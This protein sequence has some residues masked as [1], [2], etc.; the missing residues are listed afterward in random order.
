MFKHCPSCRG[1]FQNWVER[2]PDCGTALVLAEAKPPPETREELPPASE[3]VCLERGDP[4]TLHEI[5]QRF[6]AAGLSCR[7]DV[8]P[9]DGK[10]QLGQRG[11]G[12][13]TPFG[14]YV[15]ARDE[16]EAKRIRLEQ[17]RETLPEAAGH[18]LGAGAELADCP[19]CGEPL[20]E[21][22]RECA[23]CGLEFPEAAET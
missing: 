18:S 4:R 14:L 8:Y 10:I 6:Q 17:V 2:C 9:A 1:E 7:I 15:R 13:T 3:L 12:V 23:A 19:A 21:A 16:A 20:A 5:A 22:A 11:S